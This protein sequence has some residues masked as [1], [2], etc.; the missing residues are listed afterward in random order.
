[1]STLTWFRVYTSDNGRRELHHEEL[2]GDALAQKI[3][4]LGQYTPDEPYRSKFHTWF[5]HAIT[6]QG[7]K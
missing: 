2:S 7:Q 5:N 4:E 1:M 3:E 6:I